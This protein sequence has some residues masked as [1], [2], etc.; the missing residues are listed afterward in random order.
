MRFGDGEGA[1]KR[2]GVRDS[3]GTTWWIATTVEC[4]TIERWS[5]ARTDFERTP[6]AEDG[7][8]LCEEFD[9]NAVLPRRNRCTRVPPLIPEARHLKEATCLERL[10]TEDGWEELTV[11]P[12]PDWGAISVGHHRIEGDLPS[13]KV[14][15]ELTTAHI[16][17]A[18]RE[19]ELFTLTDS[20]GDGERQG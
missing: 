9:L 2:G 18:E 8:A 1:D 16:L 4:W 13:A 10:E 19:S 20:I 7:L 12:S 15:V 17:H 14:E 3:G 5:A 11:E 6:G